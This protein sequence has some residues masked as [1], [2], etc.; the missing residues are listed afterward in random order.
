MALRQKMVWCQNVYRR[1]SQQAVEAWTL[2]GLNKRLFNT[3]HFTF[4]GDLIKTTITIVCVGRFN[5]N[6]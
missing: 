3:G 1:I 2:S 6:L 5:W 4:W